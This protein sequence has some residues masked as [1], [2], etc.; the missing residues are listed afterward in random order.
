M[1]KWV[2]VAR[3]SGGRRQ[4]GW[5]PAGPNWAVRTKWAE[6]SGGLWEEDDKGLGPSNGPKGRD[7]LGR[8]LQLGRC[9]GKQRKWFGPGKRF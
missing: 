9:T 7:G 8:L 5:K 1:A 2:A 3:S 4:K 6:H